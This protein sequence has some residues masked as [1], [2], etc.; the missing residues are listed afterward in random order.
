MAKPGRVEAVEHVHLQARPEVADQVIWFYGE[1]C[2][3][4]WAGAE[5]DVKWQDGDSLTFRAD[6]LELRVEL[7]KDP[8]VDPTYRRVTL[9]LPDLE[10]AKS[11]MADHRYPFVTVSGI[12]YTDRRLTLL[13]PAGNRVEL[14]QAWPLL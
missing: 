4:K 14:K 7:V 1:L 12:N 13:D 10:E 3:L 6:K 11:M 5:L 8:D 9:L 2:L